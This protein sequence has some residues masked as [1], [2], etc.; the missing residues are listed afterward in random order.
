M[1]CHCARF[2]AKQSLGHQARGAIGD[3]LVA[4]VPRNDKYLYQFSQ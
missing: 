3:C 2:A 4:G 1:M